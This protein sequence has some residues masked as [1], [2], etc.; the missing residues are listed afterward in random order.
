MIYTL[1]KIGFIVGVCILFLLKNEQI[2]A[3]VSLEQCQELAVANYPLVKQQAL[4]EKSREYSIEN[5]S[6]AFLPQF[7]LYGQATY[8]SAVTKLPIQSPG[9]EVPVLSKDQYKIYA[10]ISQR[11][12]DGGEIKNRKLG[13]EASSIVKERALNVELYKLRERVNQLFFGI[14][15]I[16]EQLN[17]TDLLAQDLQNGLDKTQAL[18]NNGVA[19]RSNAE[20]VKAELLKTKQRSTELRAGRK[21]FTDMLGLFI[22]KILDEN[23]VFSKPNPIIPSTEIRRPELA[24]FD[25]RSRSLDVQQKSIDNRS[26]PKVDLFFQGGYG[27]PALNIFEPGFK[28][29]YIGGARI[30]WNLSGWYTN[31]KEKALLSIERKNID[32]EK[33]TFLFNTRFKMKEQYAAIAKYQ[34]LLAADEEIVELRKQVK[35]TALIQLENGVINTSDYLREVHAEDQARLNKAIHDIQLLSALYDNKA[36][37]GH[38]TK[39][40][41]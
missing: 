24:L 40:S 32:L 38:S 35:K 10:D 34:E 41:K 13:I 6:K 8:Q 7:G 19:L 22:G 12:F 9:M 16:D 25:A 5:A 26:I 28:P 4:I 20:I 27:K 33:E 2:L 23:T 11:L 31:K 17:I 37:T 36:I 21:A 18:V 1:R 39:E 30:R 3:Q 14:L 15:T 29:Y